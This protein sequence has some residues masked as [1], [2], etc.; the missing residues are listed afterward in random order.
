MHVPGLRVARGAVGFA[1]LAFLI[2]GVWGGAL[3]L[4][5]NSMNV[6]VTRADH[7]IIFWVLTALI[8]AFGLQVIYSAMF[9]SLEP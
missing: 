4:T 8:A 5:K 2:W 7:P 6:A 3:G 1:V 9:D